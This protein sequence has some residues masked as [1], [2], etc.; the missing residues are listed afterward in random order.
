MACNPQSSV[1]HFCLRN[2]IVVFSSHRWQSSHPLRWSRELRFVEFNSRM[3]WS[4]PLILVP[5]VG[6]WSRTRALPSLAQNAEIVAVLQHKLRPSSIGWLWL[7]HP[8]EELW[9][10]AFHCQERLLRRGWH[11]SRLAATRCAD[12]SKLPT[13]NARVTS[14]G[15][16]FRV[17][18]FTAQ[19]V[20]S[21][22][23]ACLFCLPNHS[24]SFLDLG[25]YIQLS[26]ISVLDSLTDGSNHE[27]EFHCFQAD[28]W[29]MGSNRHSPPT[30]RL[31]RH[32]TEMMESQMEL[33][34]MA[35][36]TQPRV[37]TVVRR[38]S[39]MLFKYQ[40]QFNW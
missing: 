33:L 3:S 30:L 19:T 18:V 32:T 16:F 39:S 24:N 25:D 29:Q 21:A 12:E 2:F 4:S 9:E 36:D 5:P 38:L 15:R 31:L 28:D 27:L 14:P 26:C 17:L 11:G 35:T 1:R 34:R 20:R 8:T 40:G 22:R 7:A 6:P 13:S 37:C 23:S 10:A